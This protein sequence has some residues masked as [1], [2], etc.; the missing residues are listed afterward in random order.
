MSTFTM[1]T[2]G[3]SG[4]TIWV[5]VGGGGGVVVGSWW[6]GGGVV[7]CGGGG[8]RGVEW[9]W[10]WGERGEGRG[11]GNFTGVWRDEERRGGRGQDLVLV[12][13]GG[14]GRELQKEK[15]EKLQVGIGVEVVV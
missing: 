11:R 6:W 8:R 9:V 7:V 1:E 15:Y 3:S 4:A 13:E 5:G 12:V 2:V 14:G 10:R